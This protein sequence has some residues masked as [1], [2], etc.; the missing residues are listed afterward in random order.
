[1][2]FHYLCIVMIVTFK[3]LKG[4][5]NFMNESFTEIFE[6]YECGLTSTYKVTVEVSKSIKQYKICHLFCLGFRHVST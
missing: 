1:M 2:L 3:D 5:A 6:K 4:A